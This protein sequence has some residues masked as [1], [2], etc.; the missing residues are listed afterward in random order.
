[1]KFIYP[2]ALLL[3]LS[4]CAQPL[5]VGNMLPMTQVYSQIP[6]NPALERKISV[7]DVVID[8]ATASQIAPVTPEIYREALQNALLTA[9][10]ATRASDSPK[11]ILD[12]RLLELDVPMF[13][14]SMDASAKAQYQLK[15]A[16]NNAVLVNETIT[17]PYHAEFSESFNANE[18]ARIAT[19]KAIRENI[20][21]LI[22]VL[23]TKTPSDLK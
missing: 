20:T 18:R 1:M 4:A 6:A 16:D 11:Y 3:L 2:V 12:A 13:G 17:L 8:E 10:F 14:F 15:R 5:P 19:A 22:R 7:G 21:H 9:N 23:A